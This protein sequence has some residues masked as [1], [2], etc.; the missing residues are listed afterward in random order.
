MSTEKR[1]FHFWGD[2]GQSLC[3]SYSISMAVPTEGLPYAP[4]FCGVCLLAL[5][6]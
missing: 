4:D 1:R 3:G 6:A 5:A 2:D